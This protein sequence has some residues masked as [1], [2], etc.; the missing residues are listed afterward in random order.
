MHKCK[1]YNGEMLVI[2]AT[3]NGVLVLRVKPFL[4]PVNKSMKVA[5]SV[6]FSGT[7]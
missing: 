4:E 1:R 2:N 7:R 6:F 5:P 3:N